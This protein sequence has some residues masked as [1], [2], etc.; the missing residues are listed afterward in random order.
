MKIVVLGAYGFTGTLVC[1]ALQTAGLDFSIAG[2]DR[3]KLTELSISSPIEI[4]EM[5]HEKQV[6]SLVDKYD[7][8][9]NCIG[10]FAETAAL[11]LQYIST[12]NKTYL[13]ITGE[14][15]F[16]QNSF[17][18]YHKTAQE[19]QATILHSCAFESVLADLLATA[20]LPKLKKIETLNSYYL[21]GKAK[22]SPGT[23]LT[24]KLSA[25][26]QTFFWKNGAKVP[27]KTIDHHEKSWQT[28]AIYTA[29]PYPLPE[30]C[31]FKW[32]TDAKNIGSYLLIDP[33]EAKYLQHSKPESK[34]KQEVL[35]AFQARKPKG[36][37]E[38]QRKKQTFTL[39]IEAED[40][41]G[42]CETIR[43][44]GSDMY[45]MTAQIIIYFVK[46][47]ITEKHIKKYGVIS[48]S[49][50]LA[51]KNDFWSYLGIKGAHIK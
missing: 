21:L 16:V 51:D 7:I 5:Q 18:E 43:L 10:P 3:A 38:Q 49:Q 11:I 42:K 15:F 14:V 29:I 34:S 26:N 36:P 24:L 37:K 17:Q 27:T 46:Q 32:N 23:R 31:F 12:G 28:M 19:H 44:Q 20:L 48:P 22:P 45:L 4:I 40:I 30:V 13:D 2:R 35:D 9:I 50:F 1:E 8:F 6:A 41:S 47:I 39:V 33:V 25:F